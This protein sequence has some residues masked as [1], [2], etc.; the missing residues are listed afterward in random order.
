MK[1]IYVDAE[2]KC[3]VINDGTMTAVETSFFDGKCDTF[4]EG[5]RLVPEDRTWTREDGKIFGGGMIAP[6]QNFN[7]L[8]AYQA[9]YEIM[10]AEL[11]EAYQNGV[12]SI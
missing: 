7:L 12:N 6:W 10:Q 4:I 8:A 3:H 11:N 9:Q 5:Y 1:T 2:F